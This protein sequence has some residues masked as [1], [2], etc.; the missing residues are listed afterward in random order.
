[1]RERVETRVKRKERNRTQENN[2]KDKQ[3]IGRDRKW[4]NRRTK[5][6]E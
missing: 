3:R 5:Y 1:M 6:E 2:S 4:I